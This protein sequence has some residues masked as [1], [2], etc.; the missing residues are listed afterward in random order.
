M[1]ET[2]RIRDRVRR[3][4]KLAGSLG[5]MALGTS[6]GVASPA[7][8]APG[9]DCSPVNGVSFIC[10]VTNVEDFAQVPNTKWVIGG[11]LS[12]ASNPQGYLYLFDTSNRS[13]TA[14]K[15]SEI[16]IRPDKQTYPD[17]PGPVAMKTFGPHGLDLSRTGGTHRVLYAVNHGGR[18]SVEVFN[19]DLSKSRPV[20]TWTGCIVAP[21]GF[22]PDAVA[23]LPDGG[24]VVTSLW[25]PT[26]AD[27]LNKLSNNQPVG[28]LD[29]WHPG[30]GWSPVPGTEG[31]S[32][33]NGVI[34]SAGGK[35][36]YLALWSGKQ[37]ARISRGITPP[38]VDTVSTGILTDNVRWAPNGKSIFVGGQDVTVK[39]TLDCFE[40]SAANCNVPFRIYRMDPATLKLTEVVRSGVYGVM[41]AGTGAIQVGNK[42][43]VSSFRAD[44]IGIFPVK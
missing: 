20:F 3:W 33:P 28:G 23:A 4:V 9:V 42:I 36:I 11:D 39:Q 10:G 25:D 1:T 12:T 13:A 31:M 27:R 26:D 17:C 30:K 8:A 44:R 40:S 34:V 19:V 5:A 29:E 14:V 18:E 6:F 15:P 16:A 43:W 7:H 2:I 22:W 24:I 32:G 37:V 35:E 41:G 38:K 21:K